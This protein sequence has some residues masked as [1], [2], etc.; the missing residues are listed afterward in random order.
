MHI[1]SYSR[2][3]HPAPQRGERKQPHSARPAA[4]LGSLSSAA[5]GTTPA[6]PCSAAAIRLRRL[7]QLAAATQ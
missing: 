2:I 6:P 7:R 5:V 1:T 3:L 4:A